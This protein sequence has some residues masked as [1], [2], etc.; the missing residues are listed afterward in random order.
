M[1]DSNVIH[2]R[3]DLLD[4]LA[5]KVTLTVPGERT[6]IKGRAKL[7]VYPGNVVDEVAF[8]TLDKAIEDAKRLGFPKKPGY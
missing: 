8:N 4:L 1:D 3:L 5:G 2:I 6:T 7:E